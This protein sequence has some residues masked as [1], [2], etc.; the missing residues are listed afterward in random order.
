MSENKKSQLNIQEI[1]PGAEEVQRELAKAKSMD[2]FF[3]KEGIF[4]R[5][6][7]NTIEQMLEAELSDHLG[8]EPYEAKGRNSGNSRNG[9][10]SKKLRT[11]AGETAIQ[12]P[13]DRNGEFDPQLVKKGQRRLP[14]FDDKVIALYAR[15]LTTREIQGHL[16][17]LYD[18]DRATRVVKKGDRVPR[19]AGL[20]FLAAFAKHLAS[21]G[22]DGVC[23]LTGQSSSPS[24]A[25]PAGCA[26]TSSSS[27][28]V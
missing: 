20:D 21:G 1:M 19:E 12:V 24:R 28:M 3:G 25:R 4:A 6:F 2:D 9:R 5:L 8:Y 13:R 10:Y 23:F 26:R 27:R 15:G 22:G 14:G 18:V 17:D 16:L 7:A 11:S